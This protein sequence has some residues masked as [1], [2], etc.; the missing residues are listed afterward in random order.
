MD[1]EEWDQVLERRSN[2]SWDDDLR[3]GRRTQKDLLIAYEARTASAA[4]EPGT[5]EHDERVKFARLWRARLQAEGW[6]LPWVNAR[7][8]TS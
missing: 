6:K 7:D 2:R 8:F 5:I 1:R 3:T 4:F